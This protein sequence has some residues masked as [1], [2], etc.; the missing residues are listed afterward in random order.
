MTGAEIIVVFGSD[1]LVIK[2]R[3][4]GYDTVDFF[5]Q[6]DFDKV[7]FWDFGKNYYDW[8]TQLYQLLNEEHEI[9]GGENYQKTGYFFTC[10]GVKHDD[11]ADAFRTLTYTYCEELKVKDPSN[12]FLCSYGDYKWLVDY[13]TKQIYYIENYYLN[14]TEK[15]VLRSQTFQEYLNS[16]EEPSDDLTSYPLDQAADEFFT[17]LNGASPLDPFS[18]LPSGTDLKPFA[19]HIVERHK[20]DVKQIKALI[21][22]LTALQNRGE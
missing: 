16:L 6:F 10:N 7:L 5:K 19:E 11:P 13:G 8:R 12:G 20:L 14:D 18:F 21:D 4:D 22:E 3:H 2:V 17:V 1:V 15:W 9:D